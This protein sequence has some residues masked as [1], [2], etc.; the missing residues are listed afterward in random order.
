MKFNQIRQITFFDI[1]AVTSSTAV[2]IWLLSDFIW[3]I[4][5]SIVVFPILVG[6]ILIV[7]IF[8]FSETIYSIVKQGWASNTLKMFSHVS[9]IGAIA[10]MILFNSELF[11]SPRIITA[12]LNDDL[13]QYRL[14]FRENGT[15]E[16]HWIGMF[17]V[18]KTYTGKYYIDGK[19]VIFE[20]IPYD[21]NFIP[22]TLLIDQDKCALFMERLQGGEFYST[23]KYLNHFEIINCP[24][25]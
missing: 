1:L 19:F 18:S 24:Q 25:Q 22:D 4:L 6:V 13:N 17:G 20:K 21:N 10:L 12:I 15:V 2:V 14:V 7:Y 23:K 11:K 8:S 5:V 9:V 3:G 16:N